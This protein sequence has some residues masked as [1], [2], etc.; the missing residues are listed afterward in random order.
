MTIS[1]DLHTLDVRGMQREVELYRRRMEEGDVMVRQL[2]G[3]LAE[4]E[5]RALQE[6]V[7]LLHSFSRLHENIARNE[8]CVVLLLSSLPRHGGPVSEWLSGVPVCT[9][10]I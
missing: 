2:R 3:S 5:A 1:F 6:K 10:R 9:S 8:Q 4:A 7:R